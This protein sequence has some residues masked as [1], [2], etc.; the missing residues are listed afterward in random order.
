VFNKLIRSNYFLSLISGIF[1]GLAYLPIKLGFLSYI[2]FIPI[3]HIWINNNHFKNGKFGLIFGVTYNLISNYWIGY[4][5]GTVISVAI[6]SL[7]LT[8]F[9]LACFW[10]ILGFIIGFTRVKINPL[11][12]LPFL[13]VS[14][15]WIR[16][17][18]PL[19]YS[20]GN[21]A[22]TQTDYISL[23]Q[24]MEYGGT[25]IVSFIIISM[26]ILFYCGFQKK[27]IIYILIN[28]LII[29]GLYITGN[30]RIKMFDDN[31]ED[32]INIAIIQP[33]IDPNEKWDYS[34][35]I[36]TIRHMDSL[37]T[38]AI[39]L[40][41]HIIIFP[42]TALPAYLRL[43]NS[44]RSKIQ[45]KVDNSKIPVLIGTV[46]R[47]F[48]KDGKKQYYNSSMYLRPKLNFEMY[49]KIHLVPFAEYDLLPNIIHPLEKLN[50]NIDRGVFKPGKI[51]KVFKNNKFYFS[52]LIC[53]ESSI[54]SIARQFIKNGAQFITIQANDGWLGTSAG[55]YQHFELARLRAI[56]NRVPIV[57]SSNT[58]ISGVISP[59]GKVLKK[60]PLGVQSVFIEKINLVNNG[61][62]YSIHGD[63]FAK[64]CSAILLF[65]FFIRCIL[66]I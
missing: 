32:S 7:L 41:P 62:Y 53:Y 12:F 66:K 22:L 64:I 44:V 39:S 40:N 23:I 27:R 33:N 15:E 55:P 54:P 18:G 60:I 28:L 57:R 47:I 50:L 20:W 43:N 11:F 58:G 37:H 6:F 30:V 49:S 46:D 2:G 8:V 34:S 14:L 21:L 59:S 65:M 4:N 56:E 35:R 19:G 63:I 1:I 13:V 16:S 51:Y 3:F 5:S 45:S 31:N 9:Y 42:E 48:D 24:S 29:L 17:F 26:N 25:F 38:I 10:Y 36:Q 52:N 61:S